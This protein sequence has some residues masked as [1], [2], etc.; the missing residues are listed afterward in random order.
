MSAAKG[1]RS[2]GRRALLARRDKV[3]G[4]LQKKEYGGWMIHAFR[5]L[6]RRSIRS[7]TRRNAKPS[8]G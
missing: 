2:C 4:H 5:M 6:A 8:E 1:P 3:T 7:A